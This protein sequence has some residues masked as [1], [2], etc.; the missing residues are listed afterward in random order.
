MAPSRALI[1]LVSVMCESVLV[2]AYAVLVG[3][4]VYILASSRK[5]SSTMHRILFSASIAMFIISV[6]HLGLVMQQ[7]SAAVVPVGN[8]QTQIVL[9][10]FQFVIGDMVLIWRVWVIWGKNYFI[11]AGPFIIM[12]IAAALTFNLATLTETRPFFTTA[13]VALIV[14]NTSICTL[15]IAGRIWWETF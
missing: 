10:V 14:A 2:G 1:E 12:I 15:L 3:L 8:F 7:F 6:V 13:P 11:A 5:A 4:L 9:S